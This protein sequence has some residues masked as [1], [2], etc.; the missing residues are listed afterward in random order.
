MIVVGSNLSE[1]TEARELIT[2]LLFRGIISNKLFNKPNES[3]EIWRNI[4]GF[5]REHP[6]PKADCNERG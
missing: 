4:R 6:Q 5:R 2:P 1:H 3:I